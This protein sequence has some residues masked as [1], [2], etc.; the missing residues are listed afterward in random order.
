[1][2]LAKTTEYA[3][4]V[5]GFMA[6][7]NEAL[8]PAEYLHQKLHIPRQYLRRL[9]T[10]LSKLG[11]IRSSKG[12]NGGFVFNQDLKEINFYNI[13]NAMEGPDA[14]KTCLL[15]FSCCI[16][17]RPC[18]MHNTWTEARSKMIEALTNTSLADLKEKYLLDQE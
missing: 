18:V 15:G 16:A 5:L 12:R 4:T 2:I 8:Y 13:I 6:T 17:D 3:L 9:L 10:D 11:Y 14:M 7:R 1:M